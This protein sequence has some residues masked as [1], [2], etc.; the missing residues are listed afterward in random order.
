M[1]FFLQLYVLLLVPL[2]LTPAVA[3]T[4]IAHWEFNDSS[5]S[6]ASDSSGHGYTALLANGVKWASGPTG[7]AV[8]A[9]EEAHQYVSIPAIDLRAAKAITIALWVNRT[10]TTAGGA[11]L[12]EAASDYRKSTTGFIVLPDD[13]ACHGIQVGLR[14]D[15]GETS[16]CYRQPSSGEWHHLAVVFDKTQSAGKEVSLYVDG[17]MQSPTWNLR[18]STNTNDFGKNPVFLFTG[19]GGSEFSSGKITDLQIYDHALSAQEIQ[20]IYNTGGLVSLTVTPASASIAKGAQ[21]QFNAA[22]AYWDGSRRDL[23][24][25]VTWTAT[26]SSVAS[27]RKAGLSTGIAT[28]STAINASLAGVNGFA[29]VMVTEPAN[30]FT[31]SAAPASVSVVRGSHGGSTITTTVSGGFNHAISLSVSASGVPSGTTV[32]FSPT[33]IAAPGSGSSAMTIVV[34]SSTAVGTYR[35][36]VTGSGGGIQHTTYVTLTVTTPNFSISASPASVSI[37]RGS[38]GSSTITT[39]VS[40]GFNHAISL[41]VSASGVPSGTTVSFSPTPIAAPGSG[42]STM[43]IA[44]G[45]STAVGTY[46]ITVTGSGGGI[47]HTTYVILTVT[48]PNFSISASPASVSV[49]QGGKISSTIT[50]TVS[51]GFNN[52]ISL[53]ASGVPSGTTV[54]FSPTPI[55]APGSGS[56]T[57]AIVVGSSTAVGTYHITVTGSGG[58]IQ[59][60]TTVTLMVIQPQVDLLWNAST[61]PVAGYNAYRSMT[62]GGAYTKLNSSLITG[63]TYTDFGVQHGY[64]YYYVTTS[65]NSQGRESAFSN[66]ASATV[67]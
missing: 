16:N 52:S 45:S 38:H 53:L 7:G 33:P 61:S 47:Q 35:I 41:S 37:A 56:S 8:A 65:V 25:S 54:S 10:Y 46:R 57:M 32:S 34:G 42:S 22:G 26:N 39:T 67:P 30:D 15:V 11:A 27:I 50:T 49:G 59:H 62:S 2:A 4:P 18:A 40:G 17:V 14:G 1:R 5:G 63:T 9:N 29:G 51:G 66:Q 19:P 31:I 43:T 60:T 12:F 23:S 36:T 6:T 24:N 3:Q 64:T 21:Q 28:G 20:Q 55:A 13:D 58:G 48:T 44:V